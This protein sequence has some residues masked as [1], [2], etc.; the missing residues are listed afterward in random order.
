VTL[1]L[2][3][4]IPALLQWEGRDRSGDL[5]IAPAGAEAVAHLASHYRV[6]GIA[7][8]GTPLDRIRR[9]LE[10]AR[11]DDLFDSVATSAVLGPTVN[12]RVIRRI[13]GHHHHGPIV[14]V[15]GRASLGRQVNR[16]RFSVVV[17]N[18]DEFGAVPEAV[19]TVLSGRVS[20]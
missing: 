4:L 1:V 14:F 10:D 12:A 11:I 3:D 6:A 20:P 19:A 16:S 7:D 5:T 17:T 8:A 2:I 13:S 15:T 9:P 18:R